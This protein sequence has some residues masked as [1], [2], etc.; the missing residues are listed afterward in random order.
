[1]RLLLLPAFL[2][3]GSVAF[4][5]SSVSGTVSDD[6]GPIPGVNIV[7]K[8]TTNGAQ[9]DFDGNYTLD[10][11][12]S[13]A[14]LV[15]SYIGYATQEI[16]VNGQST[17]NVT[18][19][20][21]VQALN[22]VVVIGYG[23]TTVRDATGSVSAVTSDDFNQGVIASPEQLI[24]GKTAG[25]Q[26]SEASGEPGAGIRVNIRG[27]NSI[28]S[29]NNPL[30]VVDGVPLTTSG[31]PA[32]GNIAFGSG[33]P[34]NPLSFLN[35]SDIESMSILKDASATAIYGSR[36]ANGVII[37]T[38]KSGRGGAKGRWEVN[39]TVSAS[40]AASEY[41][42]LSAPE[43]LEAL[44]L[45][46]IGND[47]IALNFG[48]NNDFQNFYTR[49]SASTRNDVSYS[50]SYPGGNVRASFGYS[51]LN[52]IVKNTSQERITGRVNA[53]HRFFDDK[54]KLSVQA[55]ISRVNDEAAPTSGEAGSTGDLVGASITAN[56]TWP[57]SIAFDPGSNLFNPANLLEYYLS[58]SRTNR[59]LVNASAE[60]Q[61][62]PELSGK[63]TF[64][65]DKG[66]AETISAFSSD[67]VGVNRVTGNGQGSYN[68]FDQDNTLVE[69][70]LRFQK[71][72]GNV[73]L[74]VVG[75][76][77]YQEF[78]RE[79]INAGGWGFFTN[80]LAEMHE[81]LEEQYDDVAS[82]ITGD[83][84]QFA[85]DANGNFVNRL[86]FADQTVSTDALPAG[87]RSRVRSYF[88]DT[89]DNTDELQSFFIRANV[90]IAEKYLITGT[91]RADGSSTFGP[92]NQYGYFPSGAIAWQIHKEGNISNTFST[93]KL[94]VGAGIVGNQEGLG[95][96]NFLRRTRFG[97]PGINDNGT[98][99]NPGTVFVGNNNEDL[100]WEETFDYNIGVDFGFDNDRFNGTINV[101]R[102]ET[103]DLLLNKTLAAPQVSGIPNFFSNL[104]DGTV[105]NQG[106]EVGL[107]YDFIRSDDWDFSA[108]LNVAY[109]DNVVEDT[110]QIID[111]GPINGNG[112]TGAFAQ[113]LQAGEPLFSFYMAEFTGFDANGFPTYRDVD[114]N[115]VGDPDADKTFV[116]EDAIPDITSGLSL[117]LRYK[118]FD[119][120]TYFTGQFAF[121]VYNG[122][123]NAFFTA[124]G[125]AIGKNVTQA[126]VASGEAGAATTAVST[127]FLEK[128]DFV[129]LQTASVGYS[130][131]LKDDS[132][133]DSL[134]LSLTGQNLFLI[135]D[136]SGL[137][138][139]VSSNT[140]TLNA[141]AIPSAGIEYAA[142]P[143]P[144]TVTFG[145]NAKF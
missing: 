30:F 8:G 65:Y 83:F 13:D 77:A 111:F 110:D 130:W 124:G 106:V 31:A 135:T 7:E 70:N 142:I 137:D 76:Y 90:S 39:T 82:V 74:D 56:P 92:G 112:L 81:I 18:M 133:F 11:V 17:I 99:N 117:N 24:Q 131:P 63:V 107:N 15:F 44:A 69:A 36:G 10:N 84:Q 52:G 2:L 12:A 128:G 121:S 9:S 50:R 126:A 46:R 55:S 104:D 19:Q 139:E 25:V 45:P 66:E 141:A 113:R 118:N 40:Q 144:T 21:D 22:E 23:T 108:S 72:F 95:F 57:M 4:A 96:A 62:I 145:V 97:A 53:Q 119:F 33:A 115:G 86:N 143:R 37:I 42:L 49:G 138:P 5:Q 3:I 109:N 103:K 34:R 26:I 32:P 129:R 120:A 101:Y 123:D 61:V 78:Q 43:Y 98:I 59:F 16:P 27:N 122:T 94:R 136:Y 105:V 127:R 38:T 51:N 102:K 125:L 6:V 134:R 73:N 116:G 132:I 68:T 14:T 87:F 91:F 60:Y 89:F 41:D 93:L 54:L 75:G 67:V 64:G 71:D 85:F 88:G 1:M 29:N 80:S 20:E 79:G 140:G 114:G 35:P 28:R 58:E 48:N 100:K 47:P